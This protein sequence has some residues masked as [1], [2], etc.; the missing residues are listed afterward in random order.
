MAV[1]THAG[2]RAAGPAPWFVL[3]RS[4]RC[5]PRGVR[6]AG[7]LLRPLS[8][9]PAKEASARSAFPIG[10]PSR[11]TRHGQ[12]LRCGVALPGTA[13]R[14]LGTTADK[15]VT[16]PDGALVGGERPGGWASSKAPSGSALLLQALLLR[17][18]V[19]REPCC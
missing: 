5:A 12:P 6:G 19:A 8:P 13:G 17:S 9:A 2:L 15:G 11:P 4:E 10:D 14:C 7:G 18:R 3:C 1:F 16:S